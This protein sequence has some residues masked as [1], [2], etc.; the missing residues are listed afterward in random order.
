MSE[1]WQ[2]TD[3]VHVET[4]AHYADSLAPAEHVSWKDIKVQLASHDREGLSP[5]LLLDRA[6]LQV[7]HAL[8]TPDTEHD[9]AMFEGALQDLRPV[10][11]NRELGV[12]SKTWLNA[13]LLHSYI[14]IFRHRARRES[15]PAEALPKLQQRIGKLLERYMMDDDMDNGQFGLLSELITAYGLLDQGKLPY[16][17]ST[18]EE[19]N[20]YARDNH[21]FYTLL[22]CAKNLVKKVPISVKHGRESTNSINPKQPPL[23]A[24]LAVG[25]IALATARATM[26][27]AQEARFTEEHPPL[28]IATRLAADIMV[29]HT[30]EEPLEAEDRQFL[31]A[32]G[33]GLYLP[34]KHFAEN[35]KTPNYVY[36]AQTLRRHLGGRS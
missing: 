9:G 34:L 6:W 5:S 1:M 27:Y 33:R 14:P 20:P 32:M 4:P 26:P 3:N 30:L 15:L 22:P 21:D 10:M 7:E 29:C 8:A 19:S 11:F 25:S 35:A 2:V 13:M 18:R 31:R 12:R 24:R 23:V 36:N 16:L 17:A 28:S